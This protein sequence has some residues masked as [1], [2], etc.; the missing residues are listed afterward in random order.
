AC[1]GR[2]P[3]RTSQPCSPMSRHI[4][5]STTCCCGS[6]GRGTAPACPSARGCGATW[7]PAS[8]CSPIS[9]PT[10]SPPRG[11]DR[12]C[13]IGPS[14]ACTSTHPPASSRCGPPGCTPCPSWRT[15]RAGARPPVRVSR[16]ATPQ[17]PYSTSCRV[18]AVKQRAVALAL[19]TLLIAVL[20]A[21][22]ANLLL[23]PSVY[24]DLH[25]S[26]PG[27][28][29]AVTAAALRGATDLAAVLALGAA[30]SVLFLH[31]RTARGAGRLRSGPDLTL[32]TWA[33]AA[34]TV[35]AALNVIVS[36]PES[37]GLP[38]GRL[39]QPGAFGPL[40]TFGYM[41]RA[42]TVTL[43][44][45]LILWL[46]A[47][48]GSR[49]T[50][51]LPGLWAGIVGALAPVVVGQILVGPDHDFGS[52][53]GAIRTVA[54]AVLLGPLLVAAPGQL[55]TAGPSAR[56]GLDGSRILATG[57]VGT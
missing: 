57:L 44:G 45:A 9:P 2:C 4:W 32:L 31:P 47:Y 6:W 42:W 54:A 18:G 27:L 8:P 7:P 12:P 50:T 30:V 37:N 5:V 48:R 20:P 13:S 56:R 43:V 40:Y 33:S 46:C 19:V 14:P 10:T 29:T 1:A 39:T 35:L 52:D 49:W 28:P 34:W 53:A 23:G 3:R 41:P 38:L 36:A 21:M 15:A 17:E 51:L 24:E 16:A 22:S 11:S 26:D 55:L 25:R